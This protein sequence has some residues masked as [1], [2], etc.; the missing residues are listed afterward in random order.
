[1][2]HSLLKAAFMDRINAEEVNRN[3]EGGRETKERSV[4]KTERVCGRP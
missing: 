1:M 2:K 3:P 4:R